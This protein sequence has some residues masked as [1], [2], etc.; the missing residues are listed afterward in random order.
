MAHEIIDAHTHILPEEFRARR[1]EFAERDRTF[2]ALF[3]GGDARTA[4]AEDLVASMDAAGIAKS[5]ALGYGWTD[6]ATARLSNNYLAESADA[7]RGRLIPFCSV[8]PLWGA[9]ALDEMRR[10]RELGAAG[11]GE[12][13]PDTQGLL[14]APLE[15]LAPFM[16]CARDL[17]MP[18]L[19]HA[20]E[21]VGH[22]YPGKGTAT[23]D[24]LMTLVAAYPRN[25]FIFA[26]FGGGLPFYGLMPEV[27]QALSNCRFDSAAFPLLYDSAAFDLAA[28]ALGA[29]AVL[30]A[31]DYPLIKQQRALSEMERADLPPQARERILGRNAAEWLGLD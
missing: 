20:S 26:H 7:H 11:V 3:G 4:G 1:A 15:Q 30:F 28:R 17:E 10:C 5:V 9:D 27:R 24:I 22:A 6:A 21:P 14:D 31:S 16:D 13:H 8:N 25:R 19:M 18:I 12:L 29:E 23:P 2:G